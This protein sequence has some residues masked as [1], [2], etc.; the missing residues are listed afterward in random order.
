MRLVEGG[1]F[2]SSLAGRRGR[3]TKSPPQLG[4]IPSSFDSTHSAQKVHSNVQIIASSDSGGKSLL[5]HSQFGR[6]SSIIFSKNHAL[7]PNIH[8]ASRASI[9]MLAAMFN[10]IFC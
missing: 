9:L 3:G 7:Q 10:R 4:Q 8:A 5:Q 6:N 2:S 1:Y